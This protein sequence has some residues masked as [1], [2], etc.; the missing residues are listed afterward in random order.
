MGQ[1]VGGNMPRSVCLP[2]RKRLKNEDGNI[3]ILFAV[4][5]IVL[6]GFTGLV[7]DI[8]GMY[9]NRLHLFEVGQIIRDAR[10]NETLAIDNSENPEATLND[11]A[12]TYAVLNGLDE[13]QVSVDYYQTKLTETERNYELDINLTDTYDCVFIKIF[14]I[15]TQTINVTIH[16][17]STAAKSP[18]IWAPG[19][20]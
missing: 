19:R 16:G 18:R 4:L 11:I 10:F 15:D 7:V 5:L 1:K 14:G 9:L 3:T 13:S 2:M 12:D 17:T 6:F 20:K 8:G